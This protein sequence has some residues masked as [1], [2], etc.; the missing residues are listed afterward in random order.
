M[1]NPAHDGGQRVKITVLHVSG[2]SIK[3]GIDAQC[4]I[5]IL[6]SEVLDTTARYREVDQSG[7]GLSF[8]LTPRKMK[9]DSPDKP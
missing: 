6:R 3:I 8:K 4:R 1:V 9:P 5:H 7:S 2:D